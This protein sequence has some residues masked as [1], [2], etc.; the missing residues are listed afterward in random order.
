MALQVWLPLNGNIKNQGLASDAITTF[1]DITY[2]DIGKI[3]NS[4]LNTGSI[5]VKKNYMGLEGS[6]CFWIYVTEDSNRAMIYGNND[7]YASIRNRKWSLFTYPTRNDLHSWGCLNDNSSGPNGTIQLNGVIPDNTWTHVCVTHDKNSEYVY[8]NGKLEST[9]S[10]D[11]SG[12]FTFDVETQLMYSGIGR[13]L[14]DYRIYDHTLSAREV[15]KIAKGLFCHYTLGNVDGYIMG[16]NLIQNSYI[17]QTSSVYGFANRSVEVTNGEVYTFSTMGNIT[18]ETALRVYIYEPDWSWS[19]FLVITSKTPDIQKVSFMAPYSGV[20]M[21][22]AYSF[23][24]QFTSGDNVHV[25]WYKLEKGSSATPWTPAPEDNTNLYSDKA[26]I[27]DVSGFGNNS[28]SGN[29]TDLTTYANSPRYNIAYTFSRGSYINIPELSFENM[30]QGT[31]SMWLNN[32]VQDSNWKL[33]LEFANGYNWTGQQLDFI[34]IGSTDGGN[35]VTLDCCSNAYP[36]EIKINAW[37][38]FTITWNL[39]T[40]ECAYYVNGDLWKKFTDS[41]IDTLYAS[42]HKNH[43]IGG[44]YDDT[45]PS[46]SISDFRLYSTVLSAEDVKELAK[47]NK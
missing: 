20:L 33:F 14:Q 2:K 37:Y 4:S 45:T 34:I 11:S 3:G 23:K 25:D 44:Y 24:S 39:E 10:Y 15:K 28:I 46:F 35:S 29:I 6:I 12:T 5:S 17:N 32:H 30:P 31:V 27:Y 41:K 40:H 9:I 38:L 21:I 36:Y 1:T 19:K 16:R 18:N 8:I 13:Y 7:I 47:T 22:S 42:K 26:V 43:F